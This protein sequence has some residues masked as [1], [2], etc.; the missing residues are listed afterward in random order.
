M[1]YAKAAELF[2]KWKALCEADNGALWGRDLHTPLIFVDR[3]TREAAANVGDGEG[4]FTR[5]G[6]VFVGDFPVDEAIAATAIDFK[7][8]R[9]AL[10]PWEMIGMMDEDSLLNTMS[11]EAFHCIQRELLGKAPSDGNNS[12]MNEMQTRILF[13]LE[14][15]VLLKA[16]EADGA[17]RHN[18][19]KN[20]LAIRQKRHEN[21]P[22]VAAEAA[23]E[24]MEGT[25]VYTGVKIA[26]PNPAAQIKHI[27]NYVHMAKDMQSLAGFFGYV[28]GALYGLVLDAV[29]AN[30]RPTL[31]ATD[32]LSKILL[33]TLNGEPLP[34]YDSIN[35][36]YYGY[37]EIVAAEE[38]KAATYN[39]LV[40]EMTD[41][42]TVAPTLRMFESGQLSINGQIIPIAAL[43]TVLK[44]NIEYFGAFGRMNVTDGA[45]LSRSG[46]F[47]K[48]GT[49]EKRVTAEA[50]H[51]DGKIVTGKNW[52][53]ELTDGWEVQP[54]GQNYVLKNC[55]A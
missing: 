30:W 37:S 29:G 44:G 51:I 31:T 36:E 26:L 9:W 27:A 43:G 42:F 38:A 23:F 32:D 10:V 47:Q 2:A 41:L 15:F 46:F 52:T 11:H 48:E 7:G 35:L 19:I 34:T 22:N 39:A 49:E 45:F 20:A 16:L 54:N 13:M 18:H 4:F 1:D 55:P 50:L 12:H 25:A 28:S 40:Q 53:L 21:C 17:N 5:Q 3:D 24:I 8:M 6:D 33:R 14:M